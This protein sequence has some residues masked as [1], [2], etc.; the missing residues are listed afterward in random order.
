MEPGLQL[1][2]QQFEAWLAK[3]TTQRGTDSLGRRRI[4]HAEGSVPN[5]PWGRIEFAQHQWPQQ[6][7]QYRTAVCAVFLRS[8]KRRTSKMQL[9]PGQAGRG[10]RLPLEAARKVRLPASACSGHG[11]CPTTLDDQSGP[12]VPDGQFDTSLAWRIRYK[13]APIAPPNTGTTRPT[14]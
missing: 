13:S 11:R 10:A 8:R 3:G 9:L 7:Q 2:R 4:T 5:R 14:A 6:T 1:F 12:S